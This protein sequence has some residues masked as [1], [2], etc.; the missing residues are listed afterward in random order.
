M[1]DLI[2]KGGVFGKQGTRHNVANVRVLSE[3]WVIDDVELIS[4]T[5]DYSDGTSEKLVAI[6]SDYQ[7]I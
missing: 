1:S 6:Q 4:I 5:V 2:F 7:M 3:P